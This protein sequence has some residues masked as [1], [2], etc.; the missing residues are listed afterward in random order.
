M[1]EKQGYNMKLVGLTDLPRGFYW[2]FVGR[3]EALQVW[4]IGGTSTQ[5]KYIYTFNN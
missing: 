3:H 1:E 4:V 5:L 2:T